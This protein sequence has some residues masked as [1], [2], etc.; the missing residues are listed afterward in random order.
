MKSVLSVIDSISEWSA[1]T[2]AFLV[3]AATVVVTLEV[4]QRYGFNAPTRWGLE[5]TIFI[6]GVF[7]I[8]GYAYIHSLR[9]DVRVDVIYARFTPRVRAI[10]NLVTLPLFVIFFGALM[11][12]GTGWAWTAVV[13]GYTSG[14]LWDPPIWPMRLMIPLATFL[15]LLQGLANSIRDFNIAVRG[16]EL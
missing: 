16:K 11:W 2:A 1:K 12:A 15:V 3:V 8:M 7:Y 4:I 14:S 5:L 10:I 13:K 6:C 9:A